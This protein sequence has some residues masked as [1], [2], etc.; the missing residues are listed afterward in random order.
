MLQT[1]FKSEMDLKAIEF[2]QNEIW[3]F[4]KSLSGHHQM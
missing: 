1:D 3:V 4:N 2:S